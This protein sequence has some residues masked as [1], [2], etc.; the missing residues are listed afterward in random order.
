MVSGLALVLWS[1]QINEYL[2]QCNQGPFEGSV[3]T[4][5]TRKGSDVITLFLG[6]SQSNLSEVR[7]CQSTD[8]YLHGFT[9]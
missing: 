9:T 8:S 4:I 7:K 3:I 6:Q 5:V 1:V 2:E